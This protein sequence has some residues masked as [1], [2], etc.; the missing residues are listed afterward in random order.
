MDLQ[1]NAM[2][3]SDLSYLKEVS[4]APIILGG[5]FSQNIVQYDVVDV[6]Q[7]AIANSTAVAFR[8]N[9]TAVS[10]ARNISFIGQSSISLS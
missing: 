5:L 10:N 3:I 8:G 7:L 1:E 4:Q 6:R 2:I 9:A